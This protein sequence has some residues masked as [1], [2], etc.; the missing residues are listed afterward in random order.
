MKPTAKLRQREGFYLL[1]MIKNVTVQVYSCT[2][3]PET[4]V[5]RLV[6]LVPLCAMLRM[7]AAVALPRQAL[8]GCGRANDRGYDAAPHVRV[9]QCDHVNCRLQD[10]LARMRRALPSA[11]AA[12]IAALPARVSFSCCRLQP[13]F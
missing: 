4:S 8:Q 11:A 5:L 9:Q 1:G 10:T 3:I 2:A 6:Q 7:P 12:V 13:V